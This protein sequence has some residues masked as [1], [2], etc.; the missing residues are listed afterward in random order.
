MLLI[1]IPLPFISSPVDPLIQTMSVHLVVNKVAFE[2]ASV[3]PNEP[4]MAVLLSIYIGSF[5]NGA[6]GPLFTPVSVMLIADPVAVVRM[7]I[8]MGETA[9]AI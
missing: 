3:R 9:Q 5:E 6:V 7:S 1:V 2:R 8:L 4:A